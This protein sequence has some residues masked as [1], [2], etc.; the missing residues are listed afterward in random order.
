MPNIKEGFQTAKMDHLATLLSA[1][2][3]LVR[4]AAC[5]ILYSN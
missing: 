1:I 4:D 3:L 5:N 2:G